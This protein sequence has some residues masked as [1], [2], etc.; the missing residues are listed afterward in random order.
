MRTG[1]VAPNRSGL[2]GLKGASFNGGSAEASFPV[3]L[4]GVPLSQHPSLDPASVHGNRP[5]LRQGFVAPTSAQCP[6]F[7]GEAGGEWEVVRDATVA[8]LG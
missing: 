1:C 4:L 8:T 6:P 5:N 7:H 2:G 3:A